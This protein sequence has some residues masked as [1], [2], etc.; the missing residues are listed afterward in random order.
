MSSMSW[1]DI[2]LAAYGLTVINLN[3]RPQMAVDHAQGDLRCYA[4]RSRHQ[5]LRMSIAVQVTGADL[6]TLE[7]NLSTIR[8][9]LAERDDTK[10]EIDAF[11]GR[12]WTARFSGMP[13]SFRNSTLWEGA[14]DVICHDP[15]ALAETL[16]DIDDVMADTWSDVLTV[17]GTTYCYPVI[18]LTA[19][20]GQPAAAITITNDTLAMEIQWAGAL[21]DADVLVFDSE[22]ESVTLNG[23]AAMTGVA[24]VNPRW[25][26]LKAG[27]NLIEI[28]GFTGAVKIEWRE[29]YL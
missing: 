23:D 11:S 26:L 6:S 9:L 10:L 17:G 24:G 1:N 18:T 2:G 5:P 27:D 19:D 28:E 15:A 20:G 21:L 8:G 25:P 22:A 13:G 16:E 14:V 3:M 12:Y 29:R 4:F 7:S